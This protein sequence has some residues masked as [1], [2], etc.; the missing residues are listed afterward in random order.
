MTAAPQAEPVEETPLQPISPEETTAPPTAPAHDAEP[1]LPDA[2]PAP[3]EPE[4]IAA[5]IADDSHVVPADATAAASEPPKPPARR[6]SLEEAIG[7]RWTVWVG[8]LALALGAILLVRLFD[9]ARR[10]SVRR[11]RI[12]LGFLLAAVLIGAGEFLRRRD[13]PARR[14]TSR[15][16]YIPG[17]LTA[18]G[19]IAAF[20]T[21]YAAYALYHFIGAPAAFVALGAIGARLHGGGGA[22]WAGAR[23]PRPCRMRWSRRC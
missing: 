9:R 12:A 18:T 1:A 4:A 16:A 20:G 23:R 22:A 17:M 5:S 11:V 7:T 14:A 8:G 19:T 21:I 13:T 2:Q 15:A 3:A 10:S 6:R